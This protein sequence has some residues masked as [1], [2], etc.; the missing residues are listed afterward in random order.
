LEIA[1]SQNLRVA[2]VLLFSIPCAAQSASK[3]AGNNWY[4]YGGDSGGTHYS[5]LKQITKS[6]VGQL[7]EAWRFVTPD[8]GSTEATPLIVNG[9][10]YVLSARQKVI[11]LDAVTGKQKWIFDSGDG[12]NAAT[13]GLAF[14]TDGK[15]S[16]LFSAVAS[17]IYAINA[18]D[19]TAIKDFGEGG[20]IDLRKNLDNTPANITFSIS[21]PAVIYKDMLII[22]AR[23]SENTPSAPGDERAFDV[24]TGK[25]RW[26]FHTIPAA[27]E[28]GAETWPAN[29][30]ESL[31]GGANAWAGSI[32]DTARGIVFIATGSPGDDF[33]GVHRAG[34]NLFANCVIA[35][36]ANTG[37]LL[38]YFQATHHDLWDSDFAAPPVLLTVNSNG[39]RVDAVAATNKFGF[40]YIFDRVTGKSLFPIVETKVPASTVPGEMPSETQPIPSLP[41]PLAKQTLARDEVTNRT[42]EMRAWAQ[43]QWD[44]LLGTTRVFTPLSVDKNTL[45]SPGWKGG[46]EW[47]G[48]SADPEKGILFA[49]VNNVYSLGTLAD[50]STYRQAGQGERAYRQQCQVCHGAEK[51]GTPPAIPS[52]VDVDKRLS[53]EDIAGVIQKGRGGMPGFSTLQGPALTN[54]ISYLTTGKDSLNAGGRPGG[55]GG[56]GPQKAVPNQY[57]FTG[58]RYFSDPEGYNAGGYPWGTLNAIDMNTGKYLWTVPFGE[59]TELA[60]KGL[61]D[62]GAGSHGGTILTSTGV[63]FAGG[64]EYDLKFRAYDSATGKVLWTGQLPGHGAATPATFAVNGKQYVVIAASPARGARAG[65]GDSTATGATYVVFA[66]P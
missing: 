26:T 36:N 62:T 61:T 35:L 9:T 49:N 45:I 2:A 3:A 60:A 6:N 40:V 37:K 55:G 24:H 23:V 7:K 28:P 22:G 44:T 1:L 63:L 4:S 27:G 47:G 11:A 41:K 58:Y 52:L 29:A 25:L 21:S 10:M 43:Q 8:A 54:L 33:Y 38:W 34:N 42:P 39:K 12:V 15:E 59:H 20:R 16:R 19:G 13:R 18:A 51:Q 56:G 66:L 48:M 5:T 14:W 65:N 57:M 50:A 46:V 30:R 32:V 64:S 31:L 17:Y 53:N